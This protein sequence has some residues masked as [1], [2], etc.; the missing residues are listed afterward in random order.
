LRL[1]LPHPRDNQAITFMA[2]T[3]LDMIEAWLALGGSWP[4]GE[5][6]Y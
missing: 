5:D 1:T 6:I 3:P 4:P 2:Q